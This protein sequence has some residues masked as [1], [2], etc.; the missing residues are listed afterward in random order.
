MVLD[1]GPFVTTAS[2]PISRS[3][4]IECKAAGFKTAPSG[5][6]SGLKSPHE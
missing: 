2:H 5:L 3:P 4:T 6:S 1:G